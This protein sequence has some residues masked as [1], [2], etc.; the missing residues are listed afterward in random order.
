MSGDEDQPY[1]ADIAKQMEGLDFDDLTPEAPKAKSEPTGAKKAKGMRARTKKVKPV[2]DDEVEAA[3]YTSSTVVPDGDPSTDEIFSERDVIA[4]RIAELKRFDEP[5]AHAIITDATKANLSDLAIETL[6]KPLAD[7][8]GIGVS[9]A[10]KFWR[11]TKEEAIGAANAANAKGRVEETERF[12]RKLHEQRQRESAEERDRLWSSCS[13]IAMSKTLLADMEKL[14]HRRGLVGEGASIRG[15]YL[16]ASSRFNKKSAINLLRLGAPSGGKNFVIDL[17]LALIPTECVVRMSSGSPLSLVYY[18]GEDEDA[19]KHKIIYVP[20]AAVIAEKNHVE[21]PLTVMLRILISEGRLDHNVA[22][23]QADG[24]A[25]TLHIKRNGPVAVII[26]SARDNVEDELLT[27]LMTSD[28]DESQKQTLAVLSDVLSV[29]DRDVNDTEIEQ[30]L[31]FQR[32]LMAEAPYEVVI[33]FRQAVRLAFNERWEEARRRGE[34]QKIQLRLRRDVHGVL[35]AI[36]T[37]AI[38]HKAQREK[39]ASGRIVATIDDYRH[40]HEAFDEGLARLYKTKTPETSLAVVK[41]VEEMA[42]G[43]GIGVKVTVSSLMLKLGIRALS[44]I[45]SKT[46]KTVASLSLSISLAAM[47]ARQPANT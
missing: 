45:A 22:V 16:T 41:A 13:H 9:A 40:A 5:V 37:S 28:A 35:T 17:T 10:K 1:L 36:R 21:S 34:N 4:K 18:G 42:V 33:P 25:E 7:T 30:W 14:A 24:P 43:A 2:A 26:T 19:L 11:E 3:N 44:Q 27:R 39:D 46:L 15:S 29:E 47:G 32:W 20:E 23:P 31:D 12:E 6:I 38:L 8:L